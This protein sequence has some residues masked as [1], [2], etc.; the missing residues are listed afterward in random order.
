MLIG[1]VDV[2]VVVALA[3]SESEDDE[4]VKVM[5]LKVVFLDMAVPVPMLA[6]LPN[7]VDELVMF[8]VLVELIELVE[9]TCTIPAVGVEAKVMLDEPEPPTRENNPE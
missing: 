6:A 3:T 1:A 8:I 9:L 4:L 2:A 5:E 7:D